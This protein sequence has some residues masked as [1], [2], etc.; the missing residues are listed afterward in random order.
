METTTITDLLPSNI[1][2]EISDI[3]LEA[4][5]NLCEDLLDET[6]SHDET[7]RIVELP[8]E[9]CSSEDSNS[10]SSSL[11]ECP[12]P[13]DA[14]QTDLPACLVCGR[15]AHKYIFYGARSC[16]SCS[17]RNL[18]LCTQTGQRAA[19]PYTQINKVYS[20]D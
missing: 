18:L 6:L 7:A 12:S 8:A 13:L 5:E 19:P 9:I 17:K 16:H 2:P 11:G 20:Q 3:I 10:A 1:F 15:I 4:A 14:K